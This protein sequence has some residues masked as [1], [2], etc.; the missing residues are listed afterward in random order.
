MSDQ[1]GVQYALTESF[2]SQQARTPRIIAHYCVCCRVGDTYPNQMLQVQ[3]RAYFYRWKPHI[4]LEGEEWPF[5]A[6]ELKISDG[7]M[8]A[9]QLLLRMPTTMVHVIDDDSPLAA[10]CTGRAAVAT[11]SDSE[12]VVVVSCST[13]CLPHTCDAYC[14]CHHLLL[15]LQQVGSK[16][17]ACVLLPQECVCRQG[18]HTF[19]T[20]SHMT[21]V[22]LAG[23]ELEL[24]AHSYTK[25][26]AHAVFMYHVACIC[27]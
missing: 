4:S 17:V 19:A 16:L 27:T 9:N 15:A 8:S 13:F 6:W 23:L 5:T 7:L 1:D 18:I 10:W 2:P 21:S 14:A 3:V 26:T 24:T 11:D 25:A 12:I 22:L 20:E